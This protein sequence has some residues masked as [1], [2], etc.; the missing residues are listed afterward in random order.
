MTY[1]APHLMEAPEVAPWP[2]HRRAQSVT[3]T[4]GSGSRTRR[5]GGLNAPRPEGN[6]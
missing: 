1:A 5:R 2:S 4:G 3:D 6:G